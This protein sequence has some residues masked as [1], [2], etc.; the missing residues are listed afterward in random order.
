V[1]ATETHINE[2]AELMVAGRKKFLCRPGLFGK[3]RA[4]QI[5]DVHPVIYKE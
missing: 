5:T 4:G 2:A 1:V 3:R